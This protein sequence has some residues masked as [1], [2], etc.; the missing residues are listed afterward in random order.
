MDELDVFRSFRAEV[1][2]PSTDAVDRAAARLNDAVQSRHGAYAPGRRLRAIAIALA[3]IVGA[4]TVALFVSA[5]WKSSP[6]FLERAQAALTGPADTVLHYKW[7]ETLTSVEFGCSTTGTGEM[8]IDQTAPHQYRGIFPTFGA[9]S[10]GDVMARDTR[11]L[12]CSERRV[13]EIGG[14]L[15]QPWT[16][17][18]V[19]PGTISAAT[20][21]FRSA[22][23]PV[24]QFRDLVRQALAS[25]RGHDEGKTE[26]DGRTVQRI[27]LD[28][29]PPSGCAGSSCPP[30]RPSYAYLDPETFDPV[31]V[32]T[33]DGF[34][35]VVGDG[36]F[37]VLDTVQRFST[38]EYLPRTPANLALTDLRA[39]HPEAKGP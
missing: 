8:W 4:A 30:P 11:T 10:P 3:V 6:G 1:A 5:P 29:L 24:A 23:D 22:S 28:P 2:R 34:T 15:D 36:R 27:R 19:P 31:Q 17:M 32:E 39:Q 21:T 37:V 13:A 35:L 33:P 20:A 7:T 38:F 18:F 9:D 14:E 12:A 25:G 26:L 16:I